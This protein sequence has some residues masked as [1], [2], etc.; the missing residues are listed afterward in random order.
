MTGGEPTIAIVLASVTG[1]IGIL[2]MVFVAPIW[3][4][5]HYVT[6]SKRNKGL[7]PKDERM[8]E[9]LWRT[10]RAM[11]RRME[12][13]ETIMD[14]QDPKWRAHRAGPSPHKEGY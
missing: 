5:A 8:L 14:A 7:S 11:E 12:T 3:V 1:A 13:L 2:F 4:I 9:D 10:A 6:K